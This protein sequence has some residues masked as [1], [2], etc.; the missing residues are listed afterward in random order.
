MNSEAQAKQILINV[1]PAIHVNASLTHFSDAVKKYQKGDW[2]GSTL[3]IGKFVEATI[4]ALYVYCGQTLPRGR[5][6][7]VGA[8]VKNLERLNSNQYDDTVRIL[9]PRACVFIY[10][11][12]SNRG[13]RHDPDEIDPNQM[14]ASV[15]IPTAAW[16]LAELIRFANGQNGN[17][18]TAMLLVEGLS[19]KKYPY[20]EEIDGRT[21][22]NIRGLSAREIGL[23]VLTAVYPRRI[24]REKLTDL[25]HRHGGTKNGARVATQRLT[26]VVDAD[27]DNWKLRGIG[28]QEAEQVL[29]RLRR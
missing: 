17:V 13:A 16:I 9:V 4:K 2:E 15:V 23:L 28:L 1:F 19:M 8:I 26:R 14:D 5:A 11:I 6:F 24:N 3:K 21:Y 22:I 18:A 20:F 10:D 12:A 25:I 29:S 27:N 7:K